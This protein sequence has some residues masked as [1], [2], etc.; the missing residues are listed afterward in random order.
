MSS[1]ST[2][3]GR[4]RKV[5]YQTVSRASPLRSHLDNVEW[6]PSFNP[7]ALGFYYRVKIHYQ[8]LKVRPRVSGDPSPDNPARLMTVNISSVHSLERRN[9]LTAVVEGNQ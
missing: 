8:K 7:S 6:R 9:I 4:L 1:S 3:A 5:A 2:Q